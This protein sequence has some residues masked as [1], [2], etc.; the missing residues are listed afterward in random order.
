VRPYRIKAFL[1]FMNTTWSDLQ[2]SPGLP[3]EALPGLET[4]A[5]PPH[6]AYDRFIG[7]L[8]SFLKDDEN[9]RAN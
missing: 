8:S 9:D 7:T 5:T 3:P 2:F 6:H 4:R 1:A